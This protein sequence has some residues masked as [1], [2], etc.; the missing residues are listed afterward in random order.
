M[1]E[2][3]MPSGKKTSPLDMAV[4]GQSLTKPKGEYPWEQPPK[5]TT[6]EEAIAFLATKISTTESM[7]R[8]FAALEEGITVNSIVEALTL[9]AFAEGMF[10]PNIAILI[11]E[12]LQNYIILLAERADIEYTV[13]SQPDTD[14]L[15]DKL[16]DLKVKREEVSQRLNGKEPADMLEEE[17]EIPQEEPKDGLMKRNDSLMA[18][19]V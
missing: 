7:A 17:V 14:D 10:N 18:R 11:K 4:P 1:N 5:Y 2:M 15:F 8:L 6:A 9:S 3:T 13:G 12:D 16:D 19:G